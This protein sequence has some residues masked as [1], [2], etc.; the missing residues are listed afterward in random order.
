MA[1]VKGKGARFWLL[2]AAGAPA[3]YVRISDLISVTPPDQTRDTIDTTHHGS[4]GDYREFIASLIDSG[5]A[6]FMI[7]Y[8][9]GSTGDALLEAIKVSGALTPFSI[10]VNTSTGV[11]RRMSGSGLL[12]SYA[13]SDVVIDDKMTASVTLK[14][15]GPIIFA[16]GAADPVVA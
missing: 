16:S 2:N 13:P 12:T 5:E 3:A 14:V 10:D 4:S 8:D 1:A 15:S 6:S 7:H 11:Q 9:P